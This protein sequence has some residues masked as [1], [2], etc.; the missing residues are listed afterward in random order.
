MPETFFID[1][2]GVVVLHF[3]GPVTER[4]MRGQIRP[5]LEAAGHSLPLLPGETPATN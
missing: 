4:A 5:A 1:N 3:R 2:D